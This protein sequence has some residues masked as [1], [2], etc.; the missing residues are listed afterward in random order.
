[1]KNDFEDFVTRFVE[2]QK[3][4]SSFGIGTIVI[5]HET[6]QLTRTSKARYNAHGISPYTAIGCLECVSTELLTDATS[7]V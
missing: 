7:R 3:L 6:D 1:M 2:L 4:A 5:L